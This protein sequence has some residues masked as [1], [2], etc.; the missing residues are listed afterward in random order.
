MVAAVSG[1]IPV[2]NIRLYDFQFQ[3][4]LYFVALMNK[5]VTQMRI[6]FNFRKKGMYI[7]PS[8]V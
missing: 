6:A 1:G 2:G 5:V 8:Q 3:E 4:N 7:N